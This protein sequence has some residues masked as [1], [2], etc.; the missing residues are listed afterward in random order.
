MSGHTRVEAGEECIRDEILRAVRAGEICWMQVD[1]ASEADEWSLR[2]CSAL[3]CFVPSEDL[4]RDT[5]DNRPPAPKVQPS[6]RGR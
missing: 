3:T 6:L 1:V 2:K 5:R 4:N